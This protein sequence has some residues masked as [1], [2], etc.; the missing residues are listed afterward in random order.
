MADDAKTILIID[1]EE[2][3][4]EFIKSFLEERGYSV[5][6]ALNG[7]S[8]IES[9]KNNKPALVFLDMRMPDITGLEVL[10]KLKE[11]NITAKIILMTAIDEEAEIEKAKQLGV[12][13]V[14]TKPVQLPVLSEI[15]KTNL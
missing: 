12:I 2:E 13:D 7:H 4:C 15:I 10:S 6:I 5:I 8:G 9:I 11:D 3:A 1:D 14:L